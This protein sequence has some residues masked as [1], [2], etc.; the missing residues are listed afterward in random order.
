MRPMSVFKSYDSTGEVSLT[1]LFEGGDVD[2]SSNIKIDRLVFLAARGGWPLAI[3]MKDDVALLQARDYVDAVVHYDIKRA[4]SINKDS[5]RV[6][7]LMRSI[8][9]N[10]GGQL[11]NAALA[12]NVSC[13]NDAR[14]SCHGTI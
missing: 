9:R 8:A 2:G 14:V 11:S 13:S 7:R 6:H 5:K 3:D 12:A 10:Q 1:G 4:D